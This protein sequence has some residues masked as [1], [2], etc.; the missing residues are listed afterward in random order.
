MRTL[1]NS[2][3]ILSFLLALVAC[4]EEHIETTANKRGQEFSAKATFSKSGGSVLSIDYEHTTLGFDVSGTG[5]SVMLND[6]TV[7]SSHQEIYSSN[8]QLY[9]IENGAF[10]LR[11]V[12][13]EELFGHYSGDGS[14]VNGWTSVNESW[15]IMG[16]T[17][18]YLNATGALSVTMSGDQTAPLS[19]RMSGSVYLKNI[20]DPF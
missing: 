9:K 11:N 16:G 20:S 3:A 19:A 13:G 17:G 10:V 18:K 6:F 7:E 12:N 5:Y 15:I 8:M 1:K 4:N 2:I 14:N